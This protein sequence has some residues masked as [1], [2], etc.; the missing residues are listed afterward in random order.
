VRALKRIGL[1]ADARGLAL[2]AL[3]AVWPRLVA[4]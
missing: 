1:E 3:I 4:N 2:E